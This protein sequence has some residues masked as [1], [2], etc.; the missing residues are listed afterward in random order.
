[1][2]PGMMMPPEQAAPSGGGGGGMPGLPP[3]LGS[4]IPGMGGGGG[5]AGAAA[6]AGAEGGGAAAGGGGGMFGGM[7]GMGGLASLAPVGYAAA[8]GL[9]KNTEANHA[10]TPVGDM[11]LGGLA[12]SG[13]QIWEDPIGMGLPALLG[14]PFLTPFTASDK[15]KK[16]KPEWSQLFG[17]GLADTGF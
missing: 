7:G 13:A 12:P 5:G 14:V 4:M 11:L 16:T 6:G 17:G 3:G 10:G 2:I 9:G 15:A 8:I 1:M